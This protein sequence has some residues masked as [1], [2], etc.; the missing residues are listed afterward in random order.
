M[1]FSVALQL[2][3]ARHRHGRAQEEVF[4]RIVVAKKPAMP[5]IAGAVRQKG[6]SA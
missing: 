3:K 4:A 1:A 2:S 5:G 6:I